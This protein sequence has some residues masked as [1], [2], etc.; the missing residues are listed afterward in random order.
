[1]RRSDQLEPNASGPMETMLVTGGAG[2]IGSH[3][4]EA[5]LR[6]DHEVICL[7][8]FNDYYAPEAKRRN[9]LACLTHPRFTLV[10]GDLLNPSDLERAFQPAKV[11]V[12]VHLAARAGVRPSIREPEL[13]ERV[14]VQG[15]LRMLEQARRYEV[16]KFI[17]ASSSSVYGASRLVPFHE[18][19]RVDQP[20]SPYAATKKAG[21]LWCYTYHHL[22]G[23]PVTCLRF[24]TVYGPRQRPDM[25][26][27]RFTR[28]LYRNE[29][30][31]VY[32][33][34]STQRDFTY[35][36]DIIDGVSRAIARCRG[37]HVYNLGAAVT[38]ELRH[39][40]SLIAGYLQVAPRLDFTS[41]QP[42]DVPITLA[43]ITRAREELGYSPKVALDTGL[44]R[45]IHWYLE[46]AS[47]DERKN[48][49]LLSASAGHGALRSKHEFGCGAA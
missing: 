12:V 49:A 4:C 8:N 21:E 48:P 37:Y 23:L 10:E 24:F 18:A 25:A 39:M 17:F 27:Y 16:G 46:E 11:D 14:N 34:G 28:N 3:L 15:T 19:D 45:F 1:M 40:I 6:Q 41:P 22:Y 7:D 36:T 31:P 26:I 33:D 13:Y 38:Y 2:F 5:L 9:L 20:I 30:I 35:V 44:E 29:V 43:D 47:H 32:G 42:G